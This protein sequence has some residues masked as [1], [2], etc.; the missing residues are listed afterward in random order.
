MFMKNHKFLGLWC[1]F[2]AESSAAVAAHRWVR[3]PRLSNP[4]VDPLPDSRATMAVKGVFRVTEKAHEM[5]DK[6]RKLSLSS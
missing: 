4:A 3:D 1:G 2:A 5:V 6:Q